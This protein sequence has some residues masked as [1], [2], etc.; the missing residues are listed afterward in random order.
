MKEIKLELNT[1]EI[2]LIK[3]VAGEWLAMDGVSF[4]WEDNWVAAVKIYNISSSWSE[5]IIEINEY[6]LDC[7][8]D[9]IQDYVFQGFKN[10]IGLEK[11]NIGKALFIKMMNVLEMNDPPGLYIPL[12]YLG[13]G[14]SLKLKVNPKN[15]VFIEL[16]K[17]AVFINNN[18]QN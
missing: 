7:F 6:L 4:E 8:K 5:G 12:T 14:E 2:D 11:F 3:D 18:D 10:N 15:D 13:E 16:A 17:H 9:C 1:I